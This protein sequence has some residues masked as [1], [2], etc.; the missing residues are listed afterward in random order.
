MSMKDPGFVWLRQGMEGTPDVTPVSV[1]GLEDRVHYAY[2]PYYSAMNDSIQRGAV[3]ELPTCR[4]SDV[5]I[6]YSDV[7]EGRTCA[8]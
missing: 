7:G 8:W 4:A 1:S 3:A 6:L 5:I 2:W